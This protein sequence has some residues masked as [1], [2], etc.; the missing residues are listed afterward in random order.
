[1]ATTSKT[2]QAMS[3]EDLATLMGLIKDADSV[4]LKLTVPEGTIARSRSRSARTR[5]TR[6]SDR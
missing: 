6:R 3:D 5:S 2:R 1:M 4:E